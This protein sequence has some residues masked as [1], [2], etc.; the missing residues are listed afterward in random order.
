MTDPRSLGLMNQSVRL[1]DDTGQWSDVGFLRSQ[2]GSVSYPT[3]QQYPLAMQSFNGMYLEGVSRL[4]LTYNLT[5]STGQSPLDVMEAHRHT[6][7]FRS[8]LIDT[9]ND[10]PSA[11]SVS[12]STLLQTLVSLVECKCASLILTICE[13]HVSECC[14]P[15][16]PF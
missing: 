5:V 2:N 8:T 3:M 11:S 6:Q 10:A 13:R 7:Q 15:S 14:S 1:P 12:Q 16:P 4:M 9:R